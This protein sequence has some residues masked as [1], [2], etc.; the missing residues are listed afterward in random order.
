MHHIIQILTVFLVLVFST[1]CLIMNLEER[2][3]QK[4]FSLLESSSV[5]GIIA[6]LNEFL[7][8]S[9]Q[10]RIDSHLETKS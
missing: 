4:K 8:K 10:L 5:N 2:Q 7:G 1:Y 9:C 3:Q 6:L